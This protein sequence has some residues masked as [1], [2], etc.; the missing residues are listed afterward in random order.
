M[1]AEKQDDFEAKLN[2]SGNR[3]EGMGKS[4]LSNE[5]RSRGILRIDEGE[6]RIIWISAEARDMIKAGRFIKRQW[7]RLLYVCL[8]CLWRKFD[9]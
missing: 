8:R 9:K 6:I 2:E 1:M 7:K 5:N 4:E 3:K